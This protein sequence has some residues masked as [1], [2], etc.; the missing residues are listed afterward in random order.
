MF[1]Q[2][3]KP[4]QRNELS[5]LLSAKVKKK[6][7]AE[8]LKKDRTTIWR[9]LKRNGVKIGTRGSNGNLI[10]SGYNA[11]LAKK[12][13]R[14]RRVEANKRFRK[15]DNN[16]WLRNYVIKHIKSYW[17]PD[18][19]SGRLKHKY[20]HDEK[21]QIGKDS[22]YQFIY[23]KRPDLVKYLRHQKCKY[24]RK[25]GT[26]IRAKQRE[27]AKKR[28]IDARPVVID[29]RARIGDWEGDTIVG[30]E[31]T[32]HLLTHV[33]RRSGYL[34]LDKL[35]KITAKE[36]RLVT[37]NRFKEIPNHKKYSITCDNGFTFADY[38]LTERHLNLDIYFAYPYHSWERGTNENCN[39]LIR[40]FFPKKS[41]FA[42][43]NSEDLKR[44]EY[45]LNTRP[46]KRLNY[47]TP[48]EVFNS[49]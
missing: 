4:F 33:D 20:P 24:R 22:V 46:R 18:E 17:S 21:K 14:E 5:A 10:T 37:E 23:E 45:L 34:L 44:V 8:I 35:E 9:E 13:T 43:L 26:I 27:E 25:Q 48:T 32:K 15:I 49:I 39:G 2:H 28:R 41:A 19:I 36:T 1:Y 11:R 30:S 31:K 3:F 6:T 7:I 42:N 12:K 38:E 16:K 47:L 29:L 40:Q